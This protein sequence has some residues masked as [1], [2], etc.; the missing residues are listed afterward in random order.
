MHSAREGTPAQSQAAPGHQR[1][2]REVVRRMIDTCEIAVA[3]Q[4]IVSL[5]DRRVWGC[6]ALLRGRTDALGA[7]PPTVLVESA[8]EA[9]LLDAVTR[10]VMSQALGVAEQLRAGRGEPVTMTLNLESDQFRP[11]SDLLAWLVEHV[12]ALGVPVVLELSER[13]PMPWS[14]DHDR[15]AD[16]L[17]SHGI[18]VGLDDIG[19]GQSRLTLLGHRQWD[20]I[21]L[22]RGLLLED[23]RGRGPVVLCHAAAILDEY[24][25]VGS[26]LE[27]IETAEQE[28][29]AVGLG[30]RYGQG[31]GFGAAMPATE[32]LAL[33][34]AGTVMPP[35]GQVPQDRR[36]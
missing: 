6:E 24:G 12:D 7:I 27:G 11:D 31:N 5:A 25:V 23:H 29:L 32:I 2:D 19:A 30:I 1:I 33:V 9:H 3:Y 26:L 21:K 10:E 35:I 4:P 36:R 20:L 15:V 34:D 18:G 8:A 22:D 16:E 17:A 14:D 28:A 13:Q